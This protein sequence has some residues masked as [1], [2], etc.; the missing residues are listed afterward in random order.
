MREAYQS[1]IPQVVVNRLIPCSV[2]SFVLASSFLSLLT[3]AVE[4]ALVC[5]GAQDRV[6]AY[7][8]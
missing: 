3:G 6:A 5:R 4:L 7:K 2:C 8:M 1:L